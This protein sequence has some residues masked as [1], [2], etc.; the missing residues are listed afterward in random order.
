MGLTPAALSVLRAWTPPCN[1]D[2]ASSVHASEGLRITTVSLHPKVAT[3]RFLRGRDDGVLFG[4]WEAQLQAT[5]LNLAGRERLV[6]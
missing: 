5:D 2:A 1:D 4:G 3:G 6:P